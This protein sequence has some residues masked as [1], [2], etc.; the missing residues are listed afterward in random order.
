LLA[1]EPRLTGLQLFQLAL[2]TFVRQE[3]CE[4]AG[5]GFVSGGCLA[6]IDVGSKVAVL[7]LSAFAGAANP[8]M[9]HG[10]SRKNEWDGTRGPAN[11]IQSDGSTM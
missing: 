8:E 6:V 10:A 7:P 1:L 3:T 5:P 9:G 2:N 11:Q 4:P